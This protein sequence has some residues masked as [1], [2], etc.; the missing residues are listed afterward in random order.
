MLAVLLRPFTLVL[1]LAIAYLLAWAIWPLIPARIRPV[2]YKPM[3]IIP[4][5]EVERRDWKPALY[6]VL[7]NIV[8][9]GIVGSLIA[10]Q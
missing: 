3:P 1:L 9:F 2:L 5:T 6:L 4:S 10:N 7:A 8:I